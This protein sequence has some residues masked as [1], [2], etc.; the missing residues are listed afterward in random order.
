[1]MFRDALTAT[2]QHHIVEQWLPDGESHDK[3]TTNGCLVLS[4]MTRLQPM[5]VWC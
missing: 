2:N 5:V 4:Y 1:M 3:V